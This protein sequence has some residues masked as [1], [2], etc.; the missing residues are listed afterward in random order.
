MSKYYYDIEQGSPEWFEIRRGKFGASRAADLLMKPSTIGYNNLINEIVYQ[1]IA[2]EYPESFANEWMR[3]GIELESDAIKA[4]EF[5]TFTKIERVGYVELN[6][7]CGCSPDGLIGEDT[8]IQIK[9]PKFSTHINYLLSHKVPGNYYKQCQFELMVTDRKYNI[10][11]SYR[12]K[13]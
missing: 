10:F 3:R 12:P 6:K 9:C 7:Y 4:Y 1:I 8:L 13:L 2:G 5:L 11:F